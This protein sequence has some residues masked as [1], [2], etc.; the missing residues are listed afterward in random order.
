M[1]S[2]IKEFESISSAVK[3]LAGENVRIERKIPVHGG[4]INDAWKLY[5]SDGSRLFMKSNSIENF[6]FFRKEI[7]GLALLKRT[8][9]I[10]VPEIYG[11]GRNHEENCSFLM[12][13]FLESPYRCENYWRKFGM[14][15]AEVHNAPF[16]TAQILGNENAKFGF[17]EDNYI[18]AGRQKNSPAAS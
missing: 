10:G 11:I 1:D 5:L 17:Y 12:M 9:C 8:A 16:E 4:D 2:M 13:E 6:D 3:K 15:L 18:G 7:N 14:E